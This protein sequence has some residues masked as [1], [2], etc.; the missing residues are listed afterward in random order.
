MLVIALLD[1]I[2]IAIDFLYSVHHK[3][4]FLLQYRTKLVPPANATGIL[5]LQ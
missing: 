5:L 2:L 3:S 4:V 1:A